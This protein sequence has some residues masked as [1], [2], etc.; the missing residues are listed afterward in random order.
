MQRVANSV[1]AL[2]AALSDSEV[3]LPN[4]CRE[5]ERERELVVRKTRASA[6]AEAVCPAYF[7]SLSDCYS[8]N[9]QKNKFV[10]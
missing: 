10:E 6:A 4:G 7:P 1:S 5:R 8:T 3:V 9:A 2:A